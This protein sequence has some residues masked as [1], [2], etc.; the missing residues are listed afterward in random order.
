MTDESASAISGALASRSYRFVH[1][2]IWL[3]GAFAVF[4]C[5]LLSIPAWPVKGLVRLRAAITEAINGGFGG[6][7]LAA[8]LLAVTALGAVLVIAASRQRPSTDENPAET[9]LPPTAFIR[10]ALAHLG[11]GMM[12]RQG[13]AAVVPLGAVLVCLAAWLLWPKGSAAVS[14]A[15]D[16]YMAAAIAL[17]MAF[18]SLIAERMMNTYPPQ[19]MPEAPA[20]RRILLVVT[21]VLGAAACFEV[22]RG[23]GV[24]WIGIPIKI[25]LCVSAVIAIELG[26][27]AL[28]RLFLPPPAAIDAKA[29]SDSI[30]VTLLTAGPR[31]PGLLIRTHL[32]LDFARS[33]A[34]SYLRAALVPAVGT[35][36][37]LIWVLSGLK[38]IDQDQR[39]IYERFGAPVA[40]LGPGLHLLMPWPLGRLRPVEYGT[41]H[42][43]IVNTDYQPKATE[44]IGAEVVPPASMNQLWDT[45]HASEADYLVASQG[46]GEQEFQAISAEARVLYRTGLTDEN[47]LQSVYGATNQADLVKTAAG[48]L[49][50]R[51]FASHTLDQVIGARRD[52]LSNS[53]STQLTQDVSA[54]KAGIEIVA[55]LIQSIHPP[56]GAA[57][58]Y[59]AVQAAEIKADASISNETGRAVRAKG[60][61]QQEQTQ[62]LDAAT[63]TATET[64]ANA[65]SDAY[66]FNAE[67]KAA[68]LDRSSFLMERYFENLKTALNG[69]SLTILDN[70]ITAAQAPT[71]DLR[72]FNRTSGTAQAGGSGGVTETDTGVSAP[73]SL[74][75][76]ST[77]ADAPP[78]TTEYDAEL[79]RT[80]K[81]TNNGNS[82]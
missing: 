73:P 47:A 74:A 25:L 36:L 46:S 69:R 19:A 50:T 75:G 3:Y 35:T 51:Y 12:A 72:S 49:M 7:V 59:H 40:V 53:L 28:G 76:T 18:P 65:R 20:L 81:K 34:L 55:V 62:T 80:S 48:R 44:N 24:T 37:V 6:L 31:A 45:A 82:Q 39:G 4:T 71:I 60:V 27:R 58:A 22:G 67:R 57:A 70:K 64:L 52:S 63:A 15:E 5:L 11:P 77:E 78:I 66:S 38:L 13:Q 30:I 1:R 42:T 14:V 29:V 43:A 16:A 54:Y 23:L 10:Q 21:V 79:S 26:L 68:S 56:S 8:L 41:I 61:A 33:W 2:L 17:A 9:D 32:G